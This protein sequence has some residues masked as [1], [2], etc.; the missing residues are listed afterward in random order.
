MFGFDARFGFGVAGFCWSSEIA[1]GSDFAG[2]LLVIYG[3]CF[4][5]GGWWVMG[6]EIRQ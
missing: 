1:I 4:G 3:F 5:S 2:F 6:N